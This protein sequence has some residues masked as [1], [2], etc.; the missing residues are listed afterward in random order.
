MTAD[1]LI[2]GPFRKER[3]VNCIVTELY[4]TIFIIHDSHL[5][6]RPGGIFSLLLLDLTFKSL[7]L[8]K[9]CNNFAD[10]IFCGYIFVLPINI[11]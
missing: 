3:V 11:V 7:I 5:F 9:G 6:G 8:R 2:F 1:S 4:I 10:V